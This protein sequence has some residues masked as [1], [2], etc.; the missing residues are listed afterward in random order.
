MFF[1]KSHNQT[2]QTF[3]EKTFEEKWTT[4]GKEKLF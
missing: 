4:K 2:F 1:V 3:E